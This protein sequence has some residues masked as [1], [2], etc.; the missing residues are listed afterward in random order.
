RMSLWATVWIF[1]MGGA[2]FFLIPRVGTGY[3]SRATTPSLLMSGF[4]ENVQLGQIGAVKLSS[5]VVM[6]TRLVAGQPNVQVKWRGIALDVFDGKT[7]SKTDRSHVRLPSSGG[8]FTLR[9]PSPGAAQARFEVLLEPLATTALFGPH[10]IR[11]I[12]GSF[13]GLDTDHDEAVYTRN[14]NLRRVQYEVVSEIP[15]RPSFLKRTGSIDETIEP[16]IRAQYLQ[17]P[18]KMDPRIKTLAENITKSSQT[19]L[20]KT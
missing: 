17:L 15:L 8:Q 20:E 2:L 18:P 5:A 11:S 19:V 10:R 6:R 9:P 1:L 12:Q 13:L 4:T 3:F 16:E 14:A 7:W